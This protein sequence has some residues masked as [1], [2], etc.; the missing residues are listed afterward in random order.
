MASETASLQPIYAE[1]MPSDPDELNRSF[2]SYLQRLQERTQPSVLG[3]VEADVLRAFGDF[4][5]AH[6]DPKFDDLVSTMNTLLEEDA[7]ARTT[8]AQNKFRNLYREAHEICFPTA[9]VYLKRCHEL[10]GFT[11]DW[12]F[13]Q[14]ELDRLRQ[15]DAAAQSDP[16][17]RDLMSRARQR[18]AAVKTWPDANAYRQFFDDYSE[19]LVYDLLKGRMRLSKMPEGRDPTPDFECHLDDLTFYLEVKSLDVVDA[20][21]RHGELM[22]DALEV[23]GDL[24]SQR[25]NGHILLWA[26]RE[27]APYRRFKQVEGYD[28][29]SLLTVIRTISQKARGNFKA[30]QFELGPTFGVLNLMRLGLPGQ[31]RNALAPYYCD[32]T[33]PTCCPSGVLW[34]V[35]FGKPGMLLLRWPEFEGSGNIEASLDET[36]ILADCA[37]PFPGVGLMFLDGLRGALSLYGLCETRRSWDRWNWDADKSAKV[38]SSACADYND[39][40][41]SRC[42]ALSLRR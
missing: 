31:G 19:A 41:N 32:P 18:L 12:N 30:S 4:R 29:R 23:Q 39:N 15:F 21:Q 14:V 5:L 8:D 25:R 2:I 27:I 17:F 20:E 13:A 26:E 38:L 1:E 40:S 37:S 42:F 28:P 16:N 11:S 7:P 3:Y 6:P 22:V 9:S 33:E 34:T 24:E 35:A 10:V 36:G